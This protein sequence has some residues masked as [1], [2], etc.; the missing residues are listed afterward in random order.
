ML[1]GSDQY[2][3]STYDDIYEEAWAYLCPE[4]VTDNTSVTSWESDEVLFP[5]YHEKLW[6]LTAEICSSKNQTALFEYYTVSAI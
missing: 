5:D 1:P 2:E 3:N 4:H 6:N